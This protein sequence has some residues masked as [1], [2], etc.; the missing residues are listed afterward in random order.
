[1]LGDVRA[2]ERDGNGHRF[3]RCRAKGLV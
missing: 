3:T 2:R 1:V